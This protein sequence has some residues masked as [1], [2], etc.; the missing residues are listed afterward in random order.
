MIYQSITRSFRGPVRIGGCAVLAL[1]WPIL[2]LVAVWSIGMTAEV[3]SDQ[4]KQLNSGI[5]EDPHDTDSF[6]VAMLVR[7][8]RMITPRAEIV[9]S[10]EYLSNYRL[11]IIHLERPLQKV[12]LELS[13]SNVK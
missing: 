6:K 13:I 2:G 4:L 11:L 3:R 7:E 9:T 1:W 12:S 8:I 10:Y 5:L